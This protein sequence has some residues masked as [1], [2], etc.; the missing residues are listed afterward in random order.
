MDTEKKAPAPEEARRGSL[1][2]LW[3]WSVWGVFA[4][5]VILTVCIVGMRA[6]VRH[7]IREEYAKIRAEGYPVT[8]EEL[9]KGYPAVPDAENRYVVYT[10]ALAAF[11]VVPPSLESMPVIGTHIPGKRHFFPKPS[12]PISPE[13]QKQ[14]SDFKKHYHPALEKISNASSMSGIYIPVN[15]D[16]IGIHSGQTSYQIKRI[17]EVLRIK[18]LAHCV[19]HEFRG[20]GHTFKTQREVA[21][22][23]DHY[24]G[25]HAFQVNLSTHAVAYASLQD[26]LN[27]ISMPD[28]TLIELSALL[29]KQNFSQKLPRAFV[30][31][32]VIIIEGI[33]ALS[34]PGRRSS[35]TGTSLT[36]TLPLSLDYVEWERAVLATGGYLLFEFFSALGIWEI[37]QLSTLR[38][39][40]EMIAD[41]KKPA[42][43]KNFQSKFDKKI[44]SLPLFA[45]FTKNYVPLAAKMTE[46]AMVQEAWRQNLLCTLAIER[47][48][49]KHKRLPTSFEELVPAYLPSVPVDVFDDKPLRY[50]PTAKG[51]M[52]YSVGPDGIDDKGV[53]PL[54]L[55]GTHPPGT[56][57]VTLIERP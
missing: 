43:H 33:K 37:D 56:D 20:V 3:M 8:P 21:E 24:P 16:F 18:A 2:G 45:I 50:L 39:F 47:F 7:L 35:I 10:N 29:E 53:A 14:L 52:V 46:K 44:Q 54:A 31:E 9:L 27:R 51:Y 17:E 15:L 4:L 12:D 11:S 25:W 38:L 23:L 26:S 6:Y 32:R 36:P 42:L 5:L 13:L 55:G 28:E 1:S 49:H 41:T 40:R 48:R 19:D 34:D 57:V 30:T 22:V